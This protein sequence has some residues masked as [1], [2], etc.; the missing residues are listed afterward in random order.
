MNSKL[1]L[2]LSIISILLGLTISISSAVSYYGR[3]CSC[4]AEI[5]GTPLIPCCTDSS[6]IPHISLGIILVVIGLI[7]FIKLLPNKK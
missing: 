2:M 4:P 3:A 5:I 7:V 1:A 6:T